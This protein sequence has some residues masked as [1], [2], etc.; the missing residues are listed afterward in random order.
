MSFAELYD[1]LTETGFRRYYPV[2]L[3]PLE[4]TAHL[5]VGQILVHR[6]G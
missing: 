3:P 6:L 1:S 2:S 4:V 5:T